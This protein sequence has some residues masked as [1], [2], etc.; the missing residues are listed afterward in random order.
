MVDTTHSLHSLIANSIAEGRLIEAMQIVRD[1]WGATFE[2]A[3][4]LVEDYRKENGGEGLTC[5]EVLDGK[6]ISKG[7][8][9]P[10]ISAFLLKH[11]AAPPNSGERSDETSLYRKLVSQ[12][13]A[14]QE[15]RRQRVTRCDACK[16]TEMLVTTGNVSITVPSQI[17]V[18]T[19]CGNIRLFAEDVAALERDSQFR[20]IKAVGKS[21]YR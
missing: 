4:E 18:C 5:T 20:R 13:S 14:L 3:R 15:P 2:E 16:C 10:E 9:L 21:P 11:Y 7:N 12:Q 8:T 6:R 1:A 19:Q 17:V